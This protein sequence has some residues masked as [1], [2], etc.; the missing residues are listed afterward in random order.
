MKAQIASAFVL[1][2]V[3]RRG[4]PGRSNR[5]STTGSRSRCRPS[6]RP[7]ECKHQAGPLQG[8]QRRQL[9]EVGHRDRRAREQGTRI[10]GQGEK[11]LLEAMQQNG[12][13][14][15]PAAW[16]YLGRIYL[17]QGNLVPARQRAHQGRA[18]R[19]GLRQGHRR[20]PPERLGRAGE[21]GHQLRGAEERRL[22]ARDVPA[23]G[24]DLPRLADRILPDRARSSNDKGQTDSAAYYFGQAAAAVG[25]S[26]DTTDSQ[27]PQPLGVQPGRAAAQRQEVR[28]GGRRLR[29]VPQVG[30]ER[31][32]GQARPGRGLPRQRQDRA[33]AGA[34]E[35]ARGGRRRAGGA[36]A[37]A[38][39]GGHRRT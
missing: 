9:P 16:Y 17:Q 4:R 35:G 5:C 20:L 14:K 21:G 12:Q 19:A 10:L 22:R 36:A 7:P 28:P 11:V 24:H 33:G 29:A 39:A 34:G 13:D 25:Q 1:L 31:Q 30:A 8:E 37:R 15:N 38:G 23:G 6:I 26:T 3:G 2:A 18:A 32:R 27:G